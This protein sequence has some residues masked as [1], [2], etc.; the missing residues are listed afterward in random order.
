ML[1][2]VEKEKIFQWRENRLES[3]R[4]SEQ[5]WQRFSTNFARTSH[6]SGTLQE[7]IDILCDPIHA[8]LTSSLPRWSRGPRSS[9]RPP[10]PLL[11]VSQTEELPLRP[12]QTVG[13]AG[14]VL[15]RQHL[16]LQWR[17]G[18]R[19]MTWRDLTESSW[20]CQKSSCSG[21]EKLFK[22]RLP[23]PA[24][25]LINVFPLKICRSKYQ[26]WRFICKN[27]HWTST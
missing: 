5:Q 12:S 24:S 10:V 3:F 19:Q 2:L 4:S 26:I 7:D 1:V 17:T 20:G 16:G 22:H 11:P 25:S 15:C 9:P 23:P 14:P 21:R 13:P 8:L 6:N 18:G 27:Q